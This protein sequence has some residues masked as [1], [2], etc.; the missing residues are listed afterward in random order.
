MQPWFPD[1][2]LGIFV[3]WGIYAVKGVAES[4]SF[5]TGEVPYDEYMAQADGFTAARFDADEW[6]RV[7]AASGARYAVLT[8]KHHDGMALWDTAQGDLSVV[9]RTPAGRDLVTEY[10]EAMRRHG[11]KVGLY[12]SHLDWSHP[13]YATVRP[14]DPDSYWADNRFTLPEA[15]REDPER[16]ERFLTF[17]RAQ[18]KELAERFQPDLFW[19]DGQWERDER[20]WRMKELRDELTAWAPQAVLNARMLGYGD[21]ATP[22]QGVPISPPEGPWELCYTI[23]DSWGFQHRDHNH[24]S[25]R[26]LIRTFAE[27]IG[28]GGNLLLDVGPRED[29][30]IIPEHVER[31]EGLG[32][33][34]GRHSDAIFGTVAGLPPGHHYGP[35]TLSADRRTLYLT[36]FDAPREV[37][38]VRGLRNA[39][40]SVSVVGTGEALAHRKV[41]GFDGHGVPGVLEI[42]A[43]AALDPYAT[44]LAVELDGELDLYRG[45][46][47]G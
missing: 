44:V 7:F 41:G 19:F 21:Y 15:G 30:T 25:L 33:W 31:L 26:W 14:A 6:G 1:A 36:L 32:E 43:P 9:K 35:S 16:W 47:H 5:F 13:D 3:H 28:A 18:L 42:T 12:F 22:E 39:V 10:T 29:G 38:A 17:H 34:I 4:W 2:K 20:Q 11:L 37:V 46:G 40:R 45:A 27:T 8:T 23:N 24:K